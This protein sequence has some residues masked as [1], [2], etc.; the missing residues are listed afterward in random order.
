MYRFS[1][2]TER[3]DEDNT[4]TM[5]VTSNIFFHNKK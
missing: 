5:D 3:K 2:M 1:S 4:N